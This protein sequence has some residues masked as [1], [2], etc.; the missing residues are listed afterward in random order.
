MSVSYDHNHVLHVS[1]VCFKAPEI[2]RRLEHLWPRGGVIVAYPG[3]QGIYDYDLDFDG[4]PPKGEWFPFDGGGIEVWYSFDPETNDRDARN[5]HETVLHLVR[6]GVNG[7]SFYLRRAKESEFGWIDLIPEELQALQSV[8]HFCELA[9]HHVQA[10]IAW[11]K[12]HKGDARKKCRRLL[13]YP[14]WVG[15]IE[16]PH[17]R[18]EV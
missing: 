5:F 17:E 10:D 3:Y 13:R 15:L 14:A 8:D 2:L 16:L 12:Q 6:L 1:S 9:L 11:K 4:A 7:L 18:E